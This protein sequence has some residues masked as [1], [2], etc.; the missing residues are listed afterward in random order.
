MRI[1]RENAVT[2]HGARELEPDLARALGVVLG[3]PALS[4]WRSSAEPL[5]VQR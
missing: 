1:Y 3:G 5:A 2:G 4:R